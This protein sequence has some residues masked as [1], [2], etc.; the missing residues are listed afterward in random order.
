MNRLLSLLPQEDY[1]RIKPHLEQCT[2]AFRQILYSANTPIRYVYFLNE[3]VGSLVHKMNDGK[4]SEVGTIGNEGLVGTPLLFGD[5]Q[6]PNSVYMQVPGE[7]VRM[8]A[9][10]FTAA[11]DNDPSFKRIMLHYAHAFFNQVAQSAACNHH[12]SLEQRC[13]RWLLMTYDRMHANNFLLTQEFLA[14]MLG[15]QRSGV[16]IAANALQRDG[17]IKYTHGHVTIMDVRGLR[18]RSCECYEISKREFDRLLGKDA[19]ESGSLRERV[20]VE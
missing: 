20:S 1:A 16:S 8:K 3:G 10:Q 19:K 13:C 15:V 5:W 12:H 2:L 4:A 9:E 6:A 18:E 17:L 14:M 7:G 11:L